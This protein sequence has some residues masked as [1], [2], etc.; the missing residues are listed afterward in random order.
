MQS[1]T[2]PP[3]VPEAVLKLLEQQS[4]AWNA[5]DAALYAATFAEDSTSTNIF[6]D[7]YLGRAAVTARMSEILG[8][9]FK[10]STLKLDVRRMALVR[11]DVAI[12]D[13]DARVYGCGG[14]GSHGPLRTAM[15]QV[16][17]CQ[18]GAWR[19]VAFHNVQCKSKAAE[20]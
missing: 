8:S 3:P 19:V 6:G 13:A 9:M 11:P 4:R 7:T 18:D 15:L 14:L 17:V 5:G 2:V 1:P 20:Q 10:G 16:L 12:V